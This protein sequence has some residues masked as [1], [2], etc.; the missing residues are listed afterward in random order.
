VP[1]LQSGINALVNSTQLELDQVPVASSI[2]GAFSAIESAWRSVL[3]PIWVITAQ[4]LTVSW[5]LLFLAVTDAID[6]R[7]PE[8]AL[9]RLRGRGR[10]RTLV[11]ALS[12]PAT[13]LLLALPLGVLV[14]LAA[15]TALAS[16][17]LYPGTPVSLSADCWLAAAAVTAG[18]LIAV[19][20]A[21]GR[22]L[23]RPVAEQWR[24][25]ARH[26][27]DRG[28]VVDA[29]LLT[30]AVAGLIELA[31]NG[32]VGSTS[33]STLSLLVPGLLGLA[34]AVIA[35]R[36]LPLACRAAFPRSSRRGGTS[37]YLAIRHIARR[38][39]GIRTTIVLATAFALAA[40]AVTAWS[41]N[42]DNDRAV[43]YTEAGA[44]TVLTVA[45]P[46]GQSLGTI[47]DKADPSGTKAA[48]VDKYTSISSGS[49]GTVTLAV[50]PQRFARVAF[51]EKGFSAVPLQKLMDELDPPEPAPVTVSGAAM[52][53]T[54]NVG[55][56]SLPGEQ[57]WANLT[58]G[59]TPLLIGT[60]P[61]KG[62]AT[63]TASLTGCP[64]VLQSLYLQ[65]AAL[66]QQLANPVSGSLTITGLAWQAAGA[67]TWTQARASLFTSAGQWQANDPFDPPDTVTASQAGLSWTFNSGSPAKAKNAAPTL[68]A[69]NYPNP[70]PALAPS[71]MIGGRGSLFQGVGLDGNQLPVRIVAPVEAIPGAPT[72]GFIVDRQYAE[73]AASQELTQDDQQVWLA[74]GAQSQIEPALKAAGIKI[75][76]VT[77]AAAADTQLSRQGPALVSSLFLADAGAAALLA[78]GAA[79]LGLY[80]SARRRRY[81]YAALEASGVARS[82]L[83]R[84]VGIELAVVLGFGTVVGIATGLAAAALALRAVP[85]FANPPAVPLSYMPSAG[86]VAALLGIAV[87]LLV[88]VSLV[89][90]TTIIQGV[91]LE[92]LREAPA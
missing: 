9:A 5:L 90:S 84:A 11:F 79:I 53:V 55:S 3:V 61:T 75:T 25:A 40:F 66:G 78:V 82:R 74:G 45:V 56:L 31:A 68:A 46:A 15:T 29:I 87:G 65:P 7:G 88:V 32:E 43:A 77:S 2:P 14:S 4:L 92:Q 58:T 69:V 37:S 89:L 47:V 52:R 36:V 35:S 27:A 63:L 57:L 39:G 17:L 13:L 12:E 23:R 48:V 60:L 70:M 16:L 38:P 50:D 59:A 10:L 20:V 22:T 80:L 81:E 73:L 8:V 24:R 91:R 51:W 28:W 42:R 86:P 64:C 6:A 41:V 83:R 85:E 1:R 34:V 19:I 71:S 67:T 21:A 54:V 26:A 62:T 18:G 76:S 44:P 30:G 33:H 72:N 49:S